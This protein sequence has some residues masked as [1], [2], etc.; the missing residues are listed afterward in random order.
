MS[1]TNPYQTPISL[2][3]MKSSNAPFPMTRAGLQILLF[4]F[5]NRRIS[6]AQF[7]NFVRPYL[8]SDDPVIQFLLTRYLDLEDFEEAFVLR[9]DWN[10]LKRAIFCL[11]DRAI[12]VDSCS[13][14]LP[15]PVGNLL[16]ISTLAELVTSVCFYGPQW[17][18]FVAAAVN[19]VLIV[20]AFPSRQTNP[21]DDQIQP[22]ATL[23]DLERAYRRSSFRKI[24][25]DNRHP[26]STSK[27]GL[28][29]VLGFCIAVVFGCLLSP[30]FLL[31][32]CY[33]FPKTEKRISIPA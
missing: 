6:A 29:S 4:E 9:E 2:P 10:Q 3:E 21:Y 14:V 24:R 27:Y 33:P 13:R 28:S 16:A 20:F 26:M 12:I 31:F 11:D 17:W 1:S 5:L 23:G 19:A 8:K 7:V 15:S 30:V 22:F 25:F 18:V 32:L